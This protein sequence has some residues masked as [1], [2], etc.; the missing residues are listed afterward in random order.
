MSAR[1]LSWRQAG[2]SVCGVLGMDH[3]ERAYCIN[4][5]NS[6]RQSRQGI[7]SLHTAP[8][9]FQ[10]PDRRKSARSPALLV[11]RRT[12]VAHL[13]RSLRT[14]PKGVSGAH[15]VPKGVNG[16]HNVS[17]YVFVRVVPG[18]LVTRFGA[19]WCAARHAARG[20]RRGMHNRALVRARGN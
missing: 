1:A 19:L 18:R 11:E 8:K 20:A 12:D 5:I 6:I 9:N 2:R 17:S 3:V 14:A 4:S 15:N 10:G 16:A 7:R 13:L